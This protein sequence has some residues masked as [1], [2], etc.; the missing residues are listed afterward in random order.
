[1]RVTQRMI[2]D[3]S[4]KDMTNSLSAYNDSA[5]KTSDGKQFRWA[6]DNP[7]HAAAAL[8]IRSTLEKDEAY[9]DTAN[10]LD[11]WM[12]ETTAALGSMEK[13]AT[14]AINLVLEGKTD[15]MGIEQR[16][17]AASEINMI[18]QQAIG[19]GNSRHQGQHYIFSGFQT[20][21][22]PFTLVTNPTPPPADMVTYDGD[23]GEIK[24]NIGPEQPLVG[25]LPG[26]IFT[27]AGSGI[28]NAL[29]RARDSLNN[30][31]KT[32][33]EASI[34]D[35]QR[36]MDYI[37]GKHVEYGSRQRQ[38]QASIS[39]MES[40]KIDLNSL[41]SQ[42]EDVNMAEAISTLKQQELVYQSVLQVGN[43]ALAL[44]NL[45]EMM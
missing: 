3:N 23:D 39:R 42:K 20:N 6:S 27:G 43:R 21:T 15:T 34:T 22:K 31:N 13:L 19:I 36:S 5:Q 8:S 38:L 45:F 18:F 37:N 30:D 35:L 41:L 24:R 10:S 16:Q 2:L 26:T 40:S 4:V 14:R 28:F 11:L 9:I 32:E 33:M 17:V 1:M 7:A 29:I 12:N 44:T 25:N